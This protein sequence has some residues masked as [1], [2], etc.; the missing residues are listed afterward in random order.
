MSHYNNRQLRFK[1]NW[2]YLRDDVEAGPGQAEGK[3]NE[4]WEVRK[5]MTVDTHDLFLAVFRD[6]P[7]KDKG[8]KKRSS[9]VSYNSYSAFYLLNN[10]KLLQLA[11]AGQEAPWRPVTETQTPRLQT[12]KRKKATWPSQI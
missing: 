6:R 11:A 2:F 10:L 1:F 5:E 3:G 8:L 4:N 12:E 7:K 9:T